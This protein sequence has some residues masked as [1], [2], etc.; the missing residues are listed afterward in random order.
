MNKIKAILPIWIVLA[1]LLTGCAT[2]ATTGKFPRYA[3][4]FP[5]K[6]ALI[7]LRNG[8]NPTVAQRLAIINYVGKALEIQRK[9]D[10]AA[11]IW[12]HED[13]EDCFR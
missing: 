2:K 3:L 9:R 11:R 7:A 13:A 4:V 8:E 5:P 10:C 1:I 12:N 6:Q